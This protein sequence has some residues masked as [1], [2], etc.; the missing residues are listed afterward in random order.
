MYECFNCDSIFEE[1]IMINGEARCP[2]CMS[3]DNNYE[4][5]NEEEKD[6]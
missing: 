5:E 3:S 2:K 4:V 6:E 1:P